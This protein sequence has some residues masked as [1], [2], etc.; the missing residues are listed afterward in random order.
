MKIQ[1]ASLIAALAAG[2]MLALSPALPAAE[3]NA[4]AATPPPAGRQG[5]PRMTVDE[6]VTRLTEQLTLTDEQKPKVKALLEDQAKKQA[7]FRD[8]PQEDRRAKMQAAREEMTK[9]MKEIL[10]AEQF[11]KYEALPQGRGQGQGGN[12][13]PGDASPAPGN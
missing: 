5:G 6:R 13:P 10:T 8:L 1:K 2:A 11:K 12:R 9:K 4:P 7:E 3:T